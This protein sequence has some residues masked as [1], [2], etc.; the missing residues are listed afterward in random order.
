IGMPE[1]KMLHR[2]VLFV[3]SV[4]LVGAFSI[5]V[6]SQA[7]PMKKAEVEALVNAYIDSKLEDMTEAEAVAKLRKAKSSDVKTFIGKVIEKD[8][9][10]TARALELAGKTFVEEL[11]KKVI[12]K[13]LEGPHRLNLFNMM[14]SVQSKKYME[15]LM[16]RWKD[17]D[18]KVT[19]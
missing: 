10:R 5:N 18:A 2:F 16:E 17:A 9:A 15:F 13:L 8:E 1:D 11:D 19:G 4:V 14:L 12:K 6:A 7:K 3:I